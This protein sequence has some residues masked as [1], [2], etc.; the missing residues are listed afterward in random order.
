MVDFYLGKKV[1]ENQNKCGS[2]FKTTKNNRT[3]EGSDL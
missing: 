2:V 3:K 1:F